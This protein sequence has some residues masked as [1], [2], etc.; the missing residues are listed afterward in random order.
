MTLISNLG[1]LAVGRGEGAFTKRQFVSGVLG[2]INVTLCRSNA[3]LEQ[4][5]SDFFVKASGHCLRHRRT[6]L[7]ADVEQ[8]LDTL[9]C[10]MFRVA[11]A[12]FNAGIL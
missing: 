12:T 8:S 11:F 10:A 1:D 2:K 6:H 3:R 4:G 9:L 5:G 7:T